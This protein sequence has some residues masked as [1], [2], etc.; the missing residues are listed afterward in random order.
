MGRAIGRAVGRGF[1]ASENADS[2]SNLTMIPT[3]SG[4]AAALSF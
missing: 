1:T 2:R 3:A 4:F